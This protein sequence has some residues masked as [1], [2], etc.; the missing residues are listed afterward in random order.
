MIEARA[1]LKEE[2]SWLSFD[3]AKLHMQAGVMVSHPEAFETIVMAILLEQQK[4]PDRLL[5]QLET[6]RIWREGH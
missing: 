3:C 1:L 5:A 6:V 4:L 2:K